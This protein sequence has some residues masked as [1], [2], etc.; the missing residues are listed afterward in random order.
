MKTNR[1]YELQKF[2]QSVWLDYLG[3][4]LMDSGEL[5]R[6]IEQ[7]SLRGVT[8]NPSIFEK[9]IAGTGDYDAAI[10]DLVLTGMSPAQVYEALTVEDVR[11]A[12][13]MFGR[14]FYEE[15]YGRDGFVS[16]EV[17]PHLAHDTE[18]TIAEARR[19][20]AALD[21]PNVMIKIPATREG[22]PAIRRCLADGMN[23]NITLLF[24]LERYREVVEAYLGAMEDRLARKQD[25]MPIESVASFFLSRLDTLID[26][27]LEKIAARGGQQAEL[28]RSLIG[29]TAVAS[30]QGAYRIFKAMFAS[31]RF[32]KLLEHGAHT[33]RVL[34]ASTSTKNP[35]YPDLKYVEPLVGPDTVNTMPLETFSAFRDHGRA[36]ATLEAD[37][38]R[39]DTILDGLGEVGIDLAVATERLE[40]EG[41]LKFEQAYD[42]LL[43][44]L[45]EK[46]RTLR[47]AVGTGGT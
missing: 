25:L 21:R 39:S 27:M 32:L 23:I 22:L 5:G 4:G 2:G 45:E 44:T 26:P 36:E 47:V 33:Q 9:S 3:R 16:L 15:A 7:D 20:W 13:D 30:A 28:A 34:W 42:S 37:L 24:G 29:Q 19:L 43:K 11:R 1:L 18:G 17:S 46:A 6:L 14:V 40:N 35:A 12:A 41:V 38:D 10:H 31:S 8:S